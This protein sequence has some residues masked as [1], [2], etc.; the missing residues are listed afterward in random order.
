M[1]F[2]SVLQAWSIVALVVVVGVFVSI[3]W[4]LVKEIRKSTIASCNLVE[5]IKQIRKA[6][7]M[8]YVLIDIKP[9]EKQVQ[10]LEVIIRNIGGGPAFNLNCK[11]TPDVIYRQNP[12]IT[13]SDL[14]IFK[15][16]KVLPPKEEIRF[17]FATA[18]EYMKDA[19]K[20]KEFEVFVSYEDMFKEVHNDSFHI[21]L[22]VRSILLFTEEKGLD[23]VAKEVERLTREICW[24]RR[25]I[26]HGMNG[27]GKMTQ[28]IM[29]G[30]KKNK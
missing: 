27:Y 21:D 10:V 28:E 25:S 6:E 13:I 11:F 23:D 9:K 24:L 4:Y 2:E 26:E 29:S 8:P 7:C 16:L 30:K 3:T 15:N 12:K 18:L 22:K 17:F 19:T 1:T 14:P 20:P 5:E